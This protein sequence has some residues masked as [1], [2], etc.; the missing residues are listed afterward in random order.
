MTLRVVFDENVI[1]SQSTLNCF[2]DKRSGIAEPLYHL[3]IVFVILNGILGEN[4]LTLKNHPALFFIITPILDFS[5]KTCSSRYIILFFEIS[6]KAQR[7]ISPV[8]RS[9]V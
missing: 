2:S 7:P 4:S 3:V 8:F 1:D 6:A 9:P 5:F